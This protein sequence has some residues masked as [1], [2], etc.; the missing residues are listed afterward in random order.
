MQHVDEIVPLCNIN[1][2]L[3]Q[4]EKIKQPIGDIFDD[5]FDSIFIEAT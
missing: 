4:T 3:I 2:V 1:N 5:V